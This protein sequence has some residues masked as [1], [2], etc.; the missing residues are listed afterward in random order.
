[1]SLQNKTLLRDIWDLMV[2]KAPPLGGLDFDFVDEPPDSLKC[3]ICMLV[4][5]EPWQHGDCG[6]VYCKVCIQGFIKVKNMCPNC[7]QKKPSLFK[8]GRSESVYIR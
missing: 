8:D 6:R 1:M 7:R 5:K 2:S 3:L 4:V